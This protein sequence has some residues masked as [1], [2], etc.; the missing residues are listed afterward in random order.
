MAQCQLRSRKNIRIPVTWLRHMLFR[1]VWWHVNY[2]VLAFHTYWLQSSGFFESNN[3]CMRNENWDMLTYCH[4]PPSI[5]DKI[6]T[7][8]VT[9]HTVWT[10]YGIKKTP[11]RL[12]HTICL[13][14]LCIQ[15]AV[16]VSCIF[17]MVLCYIHGLQIHWVFKSYHRCCYTSTRNIMHTASTSAPHIWRV[18]YIILAYSCVYIS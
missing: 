7:A 14:C 6:T 4:R 12:Y 16:S 5:A 2:C 18:F 13:L 15:Y 1:Y 17:F 8:Y 3:T 9:L 11:P 10:S